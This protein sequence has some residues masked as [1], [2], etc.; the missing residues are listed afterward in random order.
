MRVLTGTTSST[1]SGV[2]TGVGSGVASGVG[3][4]VATGVG[5]GVATTAVAS[6]VGVVAEV[7]G[8]ARF[9]GEREVLQAVRRARRRCRCPLRRCPHRKLRPPAPLERESAQRSGPGSAELSG[10]GSRPAR[11]RRLSR[12]RRCHTRG[13]AIHLVAGPGSSTASGEASAVEEAVGPTDDSAVSSSAGATV[14]AA[15]G[16]AVTSGVGDVLR[17]V[18]AAT[19]RDDRENSQESQY[20]LHRP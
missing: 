14:P 7:V 5:S 17:S 19:S 3:S 11:T 10:P 16:A 12:R 18:A 4:G 6:G 15:S 8:S 2:T 20:A 9:E 13:R 1:G